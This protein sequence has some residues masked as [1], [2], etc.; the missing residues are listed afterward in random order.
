[1]HEE[2]EIECVCV[3]VRWSVAT[4]YVR[5]HALHNDLLRVCTYG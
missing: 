4:K 1:M 5:F 2:V 3:C